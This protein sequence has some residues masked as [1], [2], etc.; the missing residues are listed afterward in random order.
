MMGSTKN[1]DISWHWTKEQCGDHQ[2]IRLLCSLFTVNCEAYHS[3]CFY[4]SFRGHRQ[5]SQPV[6]ECSND[7]GWSGHTSFYF[8]HMSSLSEDTIPITR[9]FTILISLVSRS[10]ERDSFL[11]PLWTV[12]EGWGGMGSLFFFVVVCIHFGAKSSPPHL[13]TTALFSP[14]SLD[15]SHTC[16]IVQTNQWQYSFRCLFLSQL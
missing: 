2:T 10:V 7:K 15:P 11:L 1:T 8:V 12:V 9:A 4:P 13:Y 5:C 3:I 6:D 14:H 16:F